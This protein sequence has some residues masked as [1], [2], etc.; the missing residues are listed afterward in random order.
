MTTKHLG[1][2]AGELDG[3]AYA[4]FYRPTMA[5]LSAHAREAAAVGPIAG[6]LL[7]PL[8]RAP[9]LLAPGDQETENGYALV[10]GA[11][12][13]AIKTEMPGV[14]ARMVDWWFA[15]HSDEPQ[16]Y[17]LWHPRAHVHAEWHKDSRDKTGYV[18]RTSV[19]DEYL[20]HTLGR[21]A[22][23]FVPPR[24]LGLDEAVLAQTK[25]TA[26]CARAGF[27]APPLD[28]GVLLHHVRPVPGGCEMR[29]RFWLGGPY[30]AARRGGPVA[31][32]AVVAARR[33]IKPTLAEGHA[34]LVHCAQEMAHLASFLPELYRENV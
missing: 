12:H 15:W 17:K 7:P 18:G 23:R 25:S 26:I 14:E 13:V 11:L 10:D 31:D 20:G 4:R 24:E 6:P 21:Y 19:V 28:G 8:A 5:P 16:R 33:V 32:L 9:E 22:I 1:M 34:L 27:A 2:V 3:K 29:S 30:A